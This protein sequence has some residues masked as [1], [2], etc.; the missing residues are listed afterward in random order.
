[1]NVNRAI[2]AAIFAGGLLAFVY[3]SREFRSSF[4]YTL[5]GVLAGLVVSA[6]G[7]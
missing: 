2:L 1:M 4:D 6:A 7:T 5:G 3:W